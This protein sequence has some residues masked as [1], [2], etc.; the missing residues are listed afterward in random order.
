MRSALLHI[1]PGTYSSHPIHRDSERIWPETNCYVDLWV[2]LLHALKLEPVAAMAF[3]LALDWEGDQWTFFKFPL[4]DLEEL[5]G[6]ETM[7]L[8]IWKPLP[9]QILTQ[10]ERG[11]SVIVE[12]DAFYLP[13]T[14]GVS[15]DIDHVKTS[16][17]VSSID[18]EAQ[19]LGYFHNRGHHEIEGRHWA[20][21]FRT[22]REPDPRNLPPYFETVKLHR[23][24]R[25]PEPEL[26]RLA[27]TQLRKHLGRCP[28]KNPVTAY[29]QT[30]GHDVAWL[31]TQ[32]IAA[33]HAYSFATLRQL[34]A[35]FECAATFLRWLSGAAGLDV[36]IAADRFLEIASAA[37]AIQFRLARVA[38]GKPYDASAS[39][40]TM[41]AAWD[42]GMGFLHT[43][44]S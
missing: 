24:R 10:L 39:L 6:V 25:L 26:A 16:I 9:Q 3:T 41:A 37:K 20:G 5:F 11:R 40:Q 36:G 12:V 35:N 29:A 28:A 17:A 22:D 44:I 31:Q 14:Q 8:A 7:E 38:S 30:F 21:V 23:L 32:P 13:D 2:E 27:L 1:D 43:S 15:Y 34:G 42:A 19:R 18:L 4:E 33:F